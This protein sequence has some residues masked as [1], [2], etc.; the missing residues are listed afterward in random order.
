MKYL[1]KFQNLE[2]YTSKKEDGILW[3]PNT[4]FIKDTKL[5]FTTARSKV[6]FAEVKNKTLHLYS[7]GSYNNNGV[8]NLDRGSV[9]NNTLK[10]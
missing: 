4:S 8:L 10:F 2:D 6:V 1:I 9:I 5:I 7:P 3:L